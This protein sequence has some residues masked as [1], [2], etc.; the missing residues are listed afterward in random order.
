MADIDRPKRLEK[1]PE[2]NATSVVENGS[3]EIE[4]LDAETQKVLEV[5]RQAR[6]RLERRIDELGSR[7]QQENKEASK[8]SPNV[9]EGSQGSPR[10]KIW[11]SLKSEG[12][13]RRNLREFSANAELFTANELEI[14]LTIINNLLHEW[15]PAFHPFLRSLLPELEQMHAIKARIEG[16]SDSATLEV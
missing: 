12:I 16:L 7:D 6:A 14:I 5:F 1:I 15:D 9:V 10:E 8:K 4:S 11:E 3:A 2:Q 13:N